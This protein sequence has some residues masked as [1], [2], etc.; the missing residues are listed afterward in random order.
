MTTKFELKTR[1]L[2]GLS[3]QT[4]TVKTRKRARTLSLIK[5]KS[6][7]NMALIF[8]DEFNTRCG[9]CGYGEHKAREKT[10]SV[11]PRIGRCGYCGV[12]TICD[13]MIEKAQNLEEE[14]LNLIDGLIAHFENMKVA[15]AVK[16]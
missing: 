1:E 5:W 3:M 8:W 10:D 12:K 13:E 7:R 14:T 2:D 6:I 11:L 9:F 4:K 15:E 16:A